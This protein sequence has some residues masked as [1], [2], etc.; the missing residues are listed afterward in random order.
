M[1]RKE[2]WIALDLI[3]GIGPKSVIRLL[4][5]FHTPE[6]II[7]APVSRI[8]ELNILKPGADTRDEP[9]C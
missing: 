1:D 8:R 4:E 9:G 7:S 2:A 3:P 6:A 5:F